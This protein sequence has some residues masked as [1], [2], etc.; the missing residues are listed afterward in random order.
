MPGAPSC[1]SP[2]IRISRIT[3][4]G[5]HE[6]SA[7]VS[8]ATNESPNRKTPCRRRDEDTASGQPQSANDGSVQAA[9][10]FHDAWNPDRCRRLDV[11]D[12]GWSGSAAQD[13]S[14]VSPIF[15]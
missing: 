2:T 1:W 14:D 11:G 5:S 13:A 15:R 4:N 6:L 3:A 12:L 9:H 7:A 10:Q 8:L